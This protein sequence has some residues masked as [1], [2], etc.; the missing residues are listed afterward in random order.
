MDIRRKLKIVW[1]MEAIDSYLPA[2]VVV[3]DT[4][5]EFS[6]W[7]SICGSEDS[8]VCLIHQ[9]GFLQ[10]YWG[11]LSQGQALALAHFIVEK[12]NERVNGISQEKASSEAV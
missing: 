2:R 12:L 6:G 4:G 11:D 7:P 9:D 3:N 5:G 10:K 1:G 8:D